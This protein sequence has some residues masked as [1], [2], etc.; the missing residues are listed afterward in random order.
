MEKL[1]KLRQLDEVIKIFGLTNEDLKL[2]WNMRRNQKVDNSG[3]KLETYFEFIYCDDAFN[4]TSSNILDFP[5]IYGLWGLKIGEIYLSFNEF[6]LV[7]RKKF[8]I[9]GNPA[10][11]PTREHCQETFNAF[12]EVKRHF[13]DAEKLLIEHGLAPV[14]SYK[15]GDSNA[16]LGLKPKRSYESYAIKSESI[17]LDG[18]LSGEWRRKI[19][20]ALTE[21][22]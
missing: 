11:H 5:K 19:V 9:N 15:R 2:W 7:D 21:S 4:L 12:E 17:Y 1:E 20:I 8:F 14:W 22:K 10:I 16:S 13:S 6:Y 18:S 3:V